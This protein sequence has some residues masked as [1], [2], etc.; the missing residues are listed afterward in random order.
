[1]II[2]KILPKKMYHLLKA[3][4]KTRHL[5]IFIVLIIIL[6]SLG[7]FISITSLTNFDRQNRNPNDL[8]NEAHDAER[9]DNVLINLNELYHIGECL[10]E[11]AGQKI[12]DIRH[13]MD[14]SKNNFKLKKDESIVTEADMESHKTIVHS[15]QYKYKTL[16]IVSEEDGELERSEI[17]ETMRTL[18]KCD[19]YVPQ[20]TDAVFNAEDLKVWIDPLDATQE[21]SG[22]VQSFLQTGRIR[23]QT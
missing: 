9:H 12:V 11:Q 5:F 4:L 18:A 16:R 8:R 7:S 2:K 14:N 10:L 20:K 6:W 19:T 21:Y 1:M 22:R 23:L 17:P 3:H 13:K 15:L